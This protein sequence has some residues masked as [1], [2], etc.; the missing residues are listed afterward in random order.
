MQRNIVMNITFRIT[1][2]KKM[3]SKTSNW[4]FFSHITG[5]QKR[6]QIVSIFNQVLSVHSILVQVFLEIRKIKS[7]WTK[8]AANIQSILIAK[9]VLFFHHET[10]ETVLTSILGRKNQMNQI[11]TELLWIDTSLNNALSLHTFF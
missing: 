3:S 11:N 9:T 10:P 4:R 6:E 1:H 2:F 7:Y 5:N 8:R